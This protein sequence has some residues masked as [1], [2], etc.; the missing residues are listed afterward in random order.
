M[1]GDGSAAGDPSVHAG[2]P[3]HH[4]LEQIGKH[5]HEEFLPL[6]EVAVGG[7]SGSLGGGAGGAFGFVD[8]TRAGEDARH[9]RATHQRREAAEGD[10]GGGRG[11][12]D[13]GVDVQLAVS[14]AILFDQAVRRGKVEL[15]VEAGCRIE[16]GI[17]E[18]S[19]NHDGGIY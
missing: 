10:R 5:P 12:D 11:H 8:R 9:G 6:F 1:Q 7:A 16:I 19:A 4:R 2:A 17:H 3:G 18:L 15:S 13:P 14:G